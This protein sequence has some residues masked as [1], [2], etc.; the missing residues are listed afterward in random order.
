MH[1]HADALLQRRAAFRQHEAAAAFPEQVD[2]QR[3]L[4]GAQL[5]ADGARR[6]MQFG[7]RGSD[8]AQPRNAF[9]GS[10]RMKRRYGHSAP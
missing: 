8:I 10:Q 4:Q 3:E 9:E 1:G 7:G 5:L 6:H 2:A